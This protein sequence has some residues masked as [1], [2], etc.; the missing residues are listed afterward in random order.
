MSILARAYDGE[1]FRGV[2]VKPNKAKAK[3]IFKNISDLQM[4]NPWT[5]SLYD[6]GLRQVDRELGNKL[7]TFKKFKKDYTYKMNE[8]LKGLKIK[9]KFSINEVTSVKGSY[10]NKIA[11]YATF[12]D[13]TQADINKK[14]LRHFQGDLSRAL[15]YLDDNKNNQAKVLDK[16][17]R[18]NTITRGK[19]LNLLKEQFGKAGEDVKLAEIIPGTNVESVYGKG[20]LEKWK[21]KG[22]D[23]QKLADEKGYFLDVKGARPYFE[24][25]EEKLKTTLI[26]L[27]E[28]KLTNK[29]QILVCNFLSNGGF[30]VTILRIDE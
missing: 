8:I 30:P 15:A 4:D 14:H 6:E 20:D 12:V 5:N 19:K 18:F 22:L 2:N 23:L 17:E 26:N 10:N 25:T 27:A 13:L 3:F 28:N 7:N 1:K 29:E 24:A 21:Q 16:I 11:P 9:D